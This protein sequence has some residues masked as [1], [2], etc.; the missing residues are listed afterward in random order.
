MLSRGRKL[1]SEEE[2][3]HGER[4]QLHNTNCTTVQHNNSH[5]KSSPAN[6]TPNIQNFQLD[7][8][9]LNAETENPMS[10][11]EEEFEPQV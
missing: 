5:D 2:Q 10:S 3:Q 1:S 9:P 11:N 7:E 8:T 4:E 6:S